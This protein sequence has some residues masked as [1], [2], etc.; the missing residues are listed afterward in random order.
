MTKRIVFIDLIRAFAILMMVQGHL[1]DA[2]LDPI[3][4]DS[5]YTIYF[6]WNFM[7]GIN[8]PIFFF[9]SGTIFVYLLMRQEKDG[10]A[11]HNPRV[12]KGF[13][14]TLIL[15]GF[16]YLLQVSPGMFKFFGTWD[17]KYLQ[18]F[19]AVHVLHV[20]GIAIL[21]LV[22]FY[23]ISR[24][25][26]IN[27]GFTFFAL[28]NLMFLFYPDV[29]QYDWN[30]LLP[31]PLANYLTKQNMSVFTVIP[32]A[33]FSLL[34]GAFGYLIF[35]YKGLYSNYLFF[36]IVIFMGLLLHFFSGFMLF[37]TYHYIIEWDNILYLGEHNFLY[38][39]LGQVLMITGILGLIARSFNI[40][41]IIT[42][43]GSET[44]SI[45]FAHCIV[46]YGS[47]T[48]FGLAQAY[49]KSLSPLECVGL[50]II[51]E[52]M[53]IAVAYFAKDFRAFVSKHFNKLKPGKVNT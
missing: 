19:F 51:V 47:L 22:V 43:I 46:I 10:S 44:L 49:G 1:V 40:P 3:Y 9:A 2:L 17:F 38:Y 11:I 39:R 26:K 28:G 16:G 4:R 50:V 18:W 41:K 52:A 31:F 20:I 5:S 37:K 6:V 35:K 25:L 7:R 30:S 8:A 21:L 33:G 48:T 42:T 34:G 14:R 36:I 24:K 32:W 29:A 12:K 23:L 13:V 45:Y 27:I 15:L 53:M